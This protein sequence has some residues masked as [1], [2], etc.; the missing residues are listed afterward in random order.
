MVHQQVIYNG[1]WMQLLYVLLPEDLW[2]PL[3]IPKTNNF[4]TQVLEY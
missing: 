4:V 3:Y 1:Q 2:Y